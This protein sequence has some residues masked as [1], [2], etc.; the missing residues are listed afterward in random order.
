MENAIA[1]DEDKAPPPGISLKKKKFVR[2]YAISADQ[3][4]PDVVWIVECDFASCCDLSSLVYTSM[5][6]YCPGHLSCTVRIF[7]LIVLLSGDACFC[8]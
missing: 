5:Q 1:T 6:N 8:F 3:F 7:F 4:T 2:K